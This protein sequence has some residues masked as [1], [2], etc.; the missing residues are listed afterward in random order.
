MA[1]SKGGGKQPR[2]TAHTSTHKQPVAV[3]TT[4]TEKRPFA[5]APS[6]TDSQ[7]Q[8]S[9]RM[10]LVDGGGPWSWHNFECS[11]LVEVLS[12]LGELE[13]SSWPQLAGGRH[14]RV[15]TAQVSREAQKRLEELAQDEVDSLYSLRLSG[16]QRVWGI[17]H[18]SCYYLLWWD[19]DHTVYPAKKKHT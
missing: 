18:G 19:P 2:A 6:L 16:T 4:T 8:L 10:G 14:H 13:K 5:G 9:W 11:G 3:A 15:A 1:R 17:L 7:D 12:K